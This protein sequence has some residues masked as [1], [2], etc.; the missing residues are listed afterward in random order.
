MSRVFGIP[1]KVS[2]FE[3]FLSFSAFCGFCVGTLEGVDFVFLPDRQSKVTIVSCPE[4]S[5]SPEK[6]QF[7]SLATRESKSGSLSRLLFGYF[8]RGG[9]RFPA[10]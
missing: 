9:F 5:G 8:I 3:R 2:I 10:G 6:F 1:G 4:F 7:L